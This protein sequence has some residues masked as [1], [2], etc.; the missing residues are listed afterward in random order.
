MGHLVRFCEKPQPISI[1]DLLTSSAPS[2][3]P[4]HTSPDNLVYCHKHVLSSFRYIV[5]QLFE[6]GESRVTTASLLSSPCLLVYVS[7]YNSDSYLQ[8][9]SILQTEPLLFPKLRGSVLETFTSNCLFLAHD[10]TSALRR[11]AK[12]S[13][14]KNAY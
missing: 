7:L 14:S 4:S 5:S 1:R 12:T 10:A 6:E 13:C 11:D 8:F 2:T 9:R 3:P